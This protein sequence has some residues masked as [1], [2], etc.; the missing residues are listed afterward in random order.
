MWRY[1]R[2]HLQT[3]PTGSVETKLWGI[4]FRSNSVSSAKPTSSCLPCLCLPPW[5]KKKTTKKTQ[6]HHPPHCPHTDVLQPSRAVHNKAA[7]M[8]KASAAGSLVTTE[9]ETNRVLFGVFLFVVSGM[10]IRFKGTLIYQHSELF[11]VGVFVC[12]LKDIMTK[13]RRWV[14]RLSEAE[15][16]ASDRAHFL[17]RPAAAPDNWLSRRRSACLDRRDARPHGGLSYDENQ[18]VS[19]EEFYFHCVFCSCAESVCRLAQ[20]PPMTG[21]LSSSESMFLFCSRPLS[22]LAWPYAENVSQKTRCQETLN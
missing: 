8:F 14:S 5:K 16:T 15:W 18:W 13:N 9:H 22:V 11:P 12:L 6:Y 7:E 19:V 3:W 17:H 1:T 2:L 10:K 4:F 21:H 20:Y